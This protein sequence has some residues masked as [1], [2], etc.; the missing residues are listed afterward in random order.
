MKSF[1]IA[2]AASSLLMSTTS[3]NSGKSTNTSNE[4]E[5]VKDEVRVEEI[6][7]DGEENRAKAQEDDATIQEFITHM[8]EKQLYYKYDFLETHCSKELLQHLKDEFEYD[9]EGYAGWL[10]RTSSQDIKSGAEGVKDKVLSITKDGEGW[11]HY[12]FTDGGWHGENK[13]KIHVE[14]GKV[15]MDALERIYDEC[16]ATYHQK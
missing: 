7:A 13:L 6:Q 10:F 5:E 16:L 11:Y 12:T 14:N 3:C 9:G 8:Y 15:M 1:L 4:T 2:V